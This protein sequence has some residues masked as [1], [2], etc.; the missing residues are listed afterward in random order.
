MSSREGKREKMTSRVGREVH[1]EAPDP[2][3]NGEG[4]GR[5]ERLMPRAER[6]KH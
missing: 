6:W 4:V 1:A 3:L 5:D 2:L